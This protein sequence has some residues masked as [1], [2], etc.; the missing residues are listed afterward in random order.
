[1]TRAA[2]RAAS[3]GS[4]TRS[5]EVLISH[6]N[7][8]ELLR[9]VLISL[10]EQTRPA[11]I[12]VVDNGSTDDT[13]EVFLENPDVRVV[14]LDRNLGFGAALNRGVADSQADL[15]VFLNNDAVADPGFVEGLEDE[16]RRTGAEMIAACLREPE[17]RV[18]SLGVE[19][20]QSLVVYDYLHGQ[21]YSAVIEAPVS[22]PLAPCAGAAAFERAAF[23][24]VGGFDES[25]FAYLEDAEL[26]LRMR[27]AGMRCA[28]APRAFVWH[29]HSATIGARSAAKNELLGWGRG[30]INWKY[31][32]QLSA[33]A[34]VRGLAVDTMVLAGKTVI[35]R[36]LGAIH[37][38][39]RARRELAGRARP[40]GEVGSLAAVPLVRLGIWTALRRRAARR[41]LGSS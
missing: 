7:R 39:V 33:G 36:N 34:R 31:G 38:R 24:A 14:R 3:D 13:D 16:W 1:M 35:D 25:I 37:G 6:W 9:R 23:L 40:G 20:D 41:S 11:A 10:R 28:V 21:P 8:A 2:D 18:E 4:P 5:V 32:A 30:Y 17:G 29:D 22:P 27:M 26:G 15:L 12:C 19:L